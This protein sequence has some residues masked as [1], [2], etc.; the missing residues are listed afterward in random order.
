MEEEEG[1]GG[2]RACK[3]V[4]EEDEGGA[5]LAVGPADGAGF[6]DVEE[7][8]EGEGGEGCGK[9]EAGEGEH[10]EELAGDFIDDDPARVLVGGCGREDRADGPEGGDGG[11]QRAGGEQSVAHKERA[12]CKA[13]ERSHRT[14]RLR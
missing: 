8:E 10:G 13:E 6:C 3:Q 4:V 9:G 1:E 2:G 12:E 11:E 5:W 14:G 7:A